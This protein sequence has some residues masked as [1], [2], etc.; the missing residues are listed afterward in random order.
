MTYLKRLLNPF[1]VWFVAFIITISIPNKQKVVVVNHT[2][3]SIIR[4]SITVV[5]DSIVYKI[6]TINKEYEKKI[7]D[8]ID[9]DDSVNLQLFARYIENYKRSIENN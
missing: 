6:K 3:D 1:N 4:D 8:I 9:A 5:N 7:V 2:R